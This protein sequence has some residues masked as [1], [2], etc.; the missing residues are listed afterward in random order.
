MEKEAYLAEQDGAM[1]QNPL[2]DIHENSLE[3]VFNVDDS[4]LWV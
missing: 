3:T 4:S 2:S 1:K